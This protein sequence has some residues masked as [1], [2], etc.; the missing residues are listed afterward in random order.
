VADK[1]KYIPETSGTADH[2][3][4]ICVAMAL[5]DGDVSVQQFHK[6]RWKDREVLALAG[7]VTVKVGEALVAKD[8]KGQGAAVEIR[9]ASGRAL[10]ETIEAPE[11]DASRP[12]SRPA[13][14]KKFHQFADPVIGEAGAKKL[15]ALVDGLEQVKDV[16]TLTQAMRRH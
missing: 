12:L 11:G 5:L 7:K 13:L 8:P 2:S 15:M 1:G 6:N 4:P 14:E 16:R 3:M 10:R 9:L